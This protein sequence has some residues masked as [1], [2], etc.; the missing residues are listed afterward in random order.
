MGEWAAA[1]GEGAAAARAMRAAAAAPASEGRSV[2][3]SREVRGEAVPGRGY[4]GLPRRL[5]AHGEG[6]GVLAPNELR[7]LLL[8]GA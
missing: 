1:V 3:S 7:R 5:V 4:S 8:P 6:G 2:L